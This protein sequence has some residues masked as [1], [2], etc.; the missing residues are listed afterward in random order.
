MYYEI[1]SRE[2]YLFYYY[3]LRLAKSLSIVHLSKAAKKKIKNNN[4]KLDR[5]LRCFEQLIVSVSRLMRACGDWKTRHEVWGL[6]D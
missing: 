2:S 4:N 3:A 1:N 6:E 5:N